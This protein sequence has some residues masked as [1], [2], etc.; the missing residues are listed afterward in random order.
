MKQN[1]KK[2]VLLFPFIL[3]VTGLLNS[4]MPVLDSL[5]QSF[6]MYF[7]NYVATPPNLLVEIARWT[8]PLATAS[9]ILLVLSRLKKSFRNYILFRRGN[10]IA[11]YGPQPHRQELLDGLAKR[12]I[13]AGDYGSDSTVVRAHDYLL[14]GDQAETIRFYTDNC[15]K[16]SGHTVYMQSEL[17]AQSVSDA[18]LRLFCPEETT[19]RLYWK[20]RDAYQ[21]SVQNN[22]KFRIVFVGFG[23]LGQQ[24]LNYALLDNI[25]NPDQTIEYHIFGDKSGRYAATHP[26]LDKIGDPVIFH[27]G[28]WYENLNLLEEA[29]LV[30]VCEQTD[31]FK[32]VQNMLFALTVPVIDVF[33]AN[34]ITFDLLEGK[35]RLR[36]FPWQQLAWEPAN[37]FSSSLFEQAMELNLH[38]AHLYSNI[39]KTPENRNAE[40][41]KLDSFTRYSNVSAA[42]YHDIRLNMMKHLG[43]PENSEE[44][45]SEQLEF[46]SELEHI[47]WCRYHQL[48]NWKPGIPENGK[49]KDSARRI[50]R[51]LIPYADL[52]EAEKQ[53]DRDNILLLLSF[54]HNNL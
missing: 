25:F 34:G 14:L 49:R 48:N 13:D 38:Y 8:A 19:A 31:Q 47:R 50:H 15:R 52:T 22:H 43:W 41:A 4:G 39:T 33:T 1:L 17:P 21:I 5:F 7:L 45:D 30:L 6:E 35:K 26:E 36:I 16:L 18:Q 11:V 54:L 32:L 12:G 53:K 37:I 28:Q 3:G 27:T 24:L 42:D 46:L 10:S 40:W 20:Q 2:S 44:L 51:D 23:T 9:G 29:A